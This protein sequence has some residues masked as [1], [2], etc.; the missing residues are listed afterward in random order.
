MFGKDGDTEVRVLQ[1][2][3]DEPVLRPDLHLRF[4][5]SILN[6]NVLTEQ[7]CWRRSTMGRILLGN[8]EVSAVKAGLPLERRDVLYSLFSQEG[9]HFLFHHTVNVTTLN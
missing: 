3:D 6:L 4:N 2:Y 7:L 1:I 5:V 8:N 9:K